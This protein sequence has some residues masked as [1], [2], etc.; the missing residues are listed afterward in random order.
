[1]NL[2]RNRSILGNR[3][4]FPQG[5]A[6]EA[7]PQERTSILTMRTPPH[8]VLLDGY[9][10]NPGDLSWDALMDLG[11]C[12]IFDRTSVQEIVPRAEDAEIVLTNKTR[13]VRETLRRLPLLQY[14][15]VLATGFDIVDVEAAAELGIL[16]TNVP[17][18]ST[19]S[20]AQCAFAHLLNLTHHVG[21]HAATVRD[22]R[23]SR[24][25]DFSYWDFPLVELHGLTLGIVG[26][27]KIGSAVARIAHAAGMT[28]IAH[29]RNPRGDPGAP[30]RLVDLDDVFRLGDVVTLHCPLTPET[31]HLVNRRRLAL[32]KSTAFLINTSR[33]GLIDEPALREALDLGRI[34]GAGLD[35]LSVEPPPPSN[36]LLGSKNCFITPH[37][38]WATRAARE[39]L[40]RAVVEN[41][42]AYLSGHPM[43]AVNRPSQAPRQ[44]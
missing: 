37:V 36:P 13:L 31:H 7:G 15:G 17:A 39:R 44:L 24:S 34:A 42:T 30:V 8:I 9:T 5:K 4:P 43:N 41:V 23:W 3:A 25:E 2:G 28:V 35:V 32:M 16:V 33:G 22:G 11:P 12:T 20:V 29:D 1:L 21:H 6:S 19:L 18:Y 10:L 14:I 40:I 38:A 27:G 26:L